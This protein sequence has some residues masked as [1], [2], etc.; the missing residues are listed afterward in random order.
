[1]D[2]YAHTDQRAM[3]EA[4]VAAKQRFDTRAPMTEGDVAALPR[5]VFA[6]D[7]GTVDELEG[8]A[9]PTP[10]TPPAHR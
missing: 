7:Q 3:V 8:V 1:M 2:V 6:Y 9:M 10:Q 5:Y 4:M